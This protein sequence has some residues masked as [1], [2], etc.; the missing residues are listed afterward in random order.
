MDDN[1][2]KPIER[3]DLGRVLESWTAGRGNQASAGPASGVEADP[4]D[5]QWLRE[6]TGGDPAALLDLIE[7][8]LLETTGLMRKVG[9]A[10]ADGLQKEVEAMV[11]SGAGAS[12]QVGA[13]NVALI[14][15]RLEQLSREGRLADAS[16]L[17]VD[18]EREVACVR[19]FLRRHGYGTEGGEPCDDGAVVGAKTS[20]TDR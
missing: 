15:R 11:H 14:L 19:D 13:G 3:E 5:L 10:V 20:S 9:A 2:K 1:V 12:A 6:L 7:T 17:L 16:C 18:L 4:I 8:Y